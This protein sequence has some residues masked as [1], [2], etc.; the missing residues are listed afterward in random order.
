MEHGAPARRTEHG[1][2]ST[3]ELWREAARLL[4]RAGF[5]ADAARLDAGVLARALLGWDQAR[6]L[7]DGR[8][9]APAGFAAH[10]EAWVAR[11]AR[12]EPVAYI[13]GRREFYG[14]TF[15]VS[16]AVLIPRPDTE[17]LVEAALAC[18]DRMA[19]GAL[20]ADVG[21]GSGCLAVTLAA[22]R[23]S[24]RVVATDI[25]AAALDVARENARCL[26]VS[27]RIQFRE[28]PLLAGAATPVDLIV[29]NPPYVREVER[30]TLPADVVAFE[31]HGALFAGADGLDVIR[32]LADEASRS[33][34]PGGRLAVEIGHDQAD[35][36]RALI[37]A[38]AGLAT[39]A[40]V[41]D[42]ESR[43]RVVVAARR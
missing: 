2:L 42:I 17:T 4:E 20:V 9:T 36:V 26:R 35:A 39:Q 41:T 32:L 31:P 21:T 37:D 40:V 7:A 34:S 33:L 25:S 22:E 8:E 14:R 23:P 13:T 11:R 5:S 27:D 15:L 43:P 30:E 12:R 1:A 24:I 6:W 19:A 16:P 28:G 29:S 10:L 38:T 18:L 3:I